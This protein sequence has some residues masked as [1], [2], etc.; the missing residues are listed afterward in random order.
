MAGVLDFAGQAKRH[1]KLAE[2]FRTLADCMHD[3]SVSDQYR[4]L[5]ETYE[6]LAMHE[7]RVA[8]GINVL[9]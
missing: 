2:G 7:A 8:A 4:K 3:Q 5:A 9:K 1:W 6:Q